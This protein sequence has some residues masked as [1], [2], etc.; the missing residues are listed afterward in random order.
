MNVVDDCVYH[1]FL[2]LV[3]YVNDILLAINDIS[4]LHET[5]RFISRIFEMKD[6]G[7]TSFILGIDL[8]ML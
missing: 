4:M 1:K 6:L 8:G 5:K 3:L 7:D 2:F